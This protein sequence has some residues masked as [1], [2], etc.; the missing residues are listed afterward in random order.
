MSFKV[1]VSAPPILPH[2]DEYKDLCLEKGVELFKPEFDVAESLNEE[3]LIT[4]LKDADG[5]LLSLIHI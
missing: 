1:L 4:L 2:I 5:I 3:E